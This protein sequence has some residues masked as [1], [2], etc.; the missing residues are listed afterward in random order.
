MI[1][2][3]RSTALGLLALASC[4]LGCTQE[5]TDVLEPAAESDG[6]AGPPAEDAGEEEAKPGPGGPAIRVMTYNI[7]YGAESGLDMGK[8]AAVIKE[9]APDVV[10]LQEV[11]EKTARSGGLEETA[12]LSKLTGLTHHHFGKNFDYDGGAYGLAILSKHPL[13]N[14]R[15]IRLDAHTQRANGYEPRIALAA[16]V[17]T[18]GALFTFVTVHASLHQAERKGNGQAIAKALEGRATRSI[19]V[20][21]FNETPGND[22]GRVLTDIGMAD[23]YLDCKPEDAFGFTS[24]SSFVLRRIDFIFRGNEFGAATD[25]WVTASQASDHLPVTAVIPLP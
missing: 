19:V 25:A 16:E 1:F 24:P 21:D 20:G 5:R 8:L 10:G 12:E 13:V 4:A 18:P 11:D 7:K 2:D 23:A 22:V 3:V 17:E 14:P 9:S 6:G 15:V